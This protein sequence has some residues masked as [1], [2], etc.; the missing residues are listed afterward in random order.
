M[1]NRS[2]T[3]MHFA[4]G[5]VVVAGAA[6]AAFL[7]WKSIYVP[8]Q[9]RQQALLRS[10]CASNMALMRMGI[11]D[12]W[13]RHRSFPPA[14]VIGKDGQTIHSWRVLI[15]HQLEEPSLYDQYDFSQ[16]WDSPNNIKV[17][18]EGTRRLG[19][20]FACPADQEAH[21]NGRTSYVAV[22]GKNTLWPGTRGPDLDTLRDAGDKI[23]LIEIPH[24][25][26]RW[27]EPRDITLEEALELFQR[28]K[29]G[30]RDSPH[31][32]GLNYVTLDGPCGRLSDIESVE[33][34]AE[35]LQLDPREDE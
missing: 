26:I 5:S 14:Y 11:V 12:W 18:E 35:M 22:I 24:S 10:S 33:Q 6:A 19:R 2:G 7:Y 32:H 1:P 3:W 34:F 15:L 31:P 27:T 4:I 25:D 23:L 21:E 30:L 16:P 17:W 8:A 9:R 28:E 20:Y 13:T 29:D